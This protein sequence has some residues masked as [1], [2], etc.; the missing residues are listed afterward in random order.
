M[1]HFLPI[2][3]L[4]CITFV[5]AQPI[6]E[7]TPLGFTPVELTTPDKPFEKLL[8]A[9]KS[10]AAFY[11]KKGHDVF[12]VT[13]NSL[14]VQA[15]KEYAYI[16]RNLGVTYDYNIIYTLKVVFKEDKKYTLTFS[17]KEIYSGEVLTKTT[18][19]DFF[20]PEGKLKDDYP[21]VK[22]SLQKTAERIIKSYADYISQ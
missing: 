11:N 22:E 12:D 2:A 17:V 14:S 16:D 15:L 9:S 19:P 5:A 4:F 7:M 6:I 18:V 10:W 8:Q 21:E 13:D 20:T 3:L 1:K